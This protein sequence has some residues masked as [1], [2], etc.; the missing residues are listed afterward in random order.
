MIFRGGYR[1][2]EWVITCHKL[3][4]GSRYN[5]NL[6]LPSCDMNRSPPISETF[7]E[8]IHSNWIFSGGSNNPGI[9]ENFREISSLHLLLSK[10]FQSE[11]TRLQKQHT[12]WYHFLSLNN[13]YCTS[14]I[15]TGLL[16]EK[17]YKINLKITIL[18]TLCTQARQ[19][20]WSFSIQGLKEKLFLPKLTRLDDKNF[21]IINF[22]I[23]FAT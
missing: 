20:K 14:T 19:W 23:I 21:H 10:C 13:R 9:Q 1:S 18:Q 7:G 4:S 16:T 8:G 12:L 11:V 22:I 17:L 6:S 2:E 3:Y 15:Y 5:V